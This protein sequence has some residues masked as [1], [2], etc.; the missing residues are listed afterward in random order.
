M[1]NI[2]RVWSILLVVALAGSV[3]LVSQ[4]WIGDLTVYD[5]VV[6][7]R[8]DIVH[9]AIL[10]NQFPAGAGSWD[11][12]GANGVNVRIATVYLAELVHRITKINLTKV[13][14]VI[15]TVAL[16]SAFLLLFKYLQQT[17]PSIYAIAGALYVA[18]VLPLSYLFT[19][20]Q[21][22]DRMSL[23]LWI[24]L[25]M[26][27][28]SERLLLF[29]LLLIISITIKYDTILLPG[30]YFLVNISWTN[31]RKVVFRTACL[32]V[33]SFGTWFA[34]RSLLPGGFER[35]DVVKQLFINFADF[36]STLLTYPPLLTFFVPIVLAC[37][38][39]RYSDRFCRASVVFGL[40]L[41]VPLFTGSNFIEVRA[42][43]P[44]L[45]LLLPSALIALRRL[46][47]R[48]MAASARQPTS[49]VQPERAAALAG[50][51]HFG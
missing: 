47:E 15:D 32:F 39:F 9:N 30:L 35:G 5:Q 6:E 3:T 11:E 28:R 33:V 20:F 44:V 31:Q 49:A 40:F 45:I 4:K 1:S 18:T 17:G 51:A 14:R 36:R 34:I 27:L 12:V 42:Q 22:W 7:Q 29:A 2:Y 46:C 26:L 13:Y 21:P 10:N 16:F 24:A 50:S 23:L 8:R 19:Y 48:E 37:I 25:V 38:G 43:L 41:F